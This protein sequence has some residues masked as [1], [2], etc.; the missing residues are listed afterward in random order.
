[1]DAAVE[2][3]RHVERPV[4]SERE[5]RRVGEVRHK[6]LARTVRPDDEDRH[7]PLLSTR[8]AERHVDIARGIDGGTI[9]LMETR[10]QRG[11]NL[12]VH[13]FPSDLLDAY[14]R[15]PPSSP[16]GIIAVNSRDEA[17]VM[18]AGLP[19]MS[20]RG[21]TGSTRKPVPSMVMYPPSTAQSGRTPEMRDE[22]EE[23]IGK[24]QRCTPRGRLPGGERIKLSVE[25]HI[26]VEVVAPAVRSVLEA[27]GDPDRRRLVRTFGHTYQVHAG[28]RRRAPAFPAIA[29]DTAGDDVLP[30]LA[31]ALGDR[32]HMIEGQ[33]RRRKHLAAVLTE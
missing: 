25:L 7:G 18:R 15:W 4:R 29:A 9:N 6:W 17:L 33:L 30:V 11:A 23:V 19:P 26:P 31:A 32:H 16:G 13:S 22:L 8:T 5:R 2:P 21:S 12:D 27:D 24:F 1:M 20:T 10:S 28:L 14:R 3:A